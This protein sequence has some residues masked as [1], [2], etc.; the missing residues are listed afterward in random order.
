MA[1]IYI[2]VAEFKAHLSE[3]LRESTVNRKT[4]VVTRRNRPLVSIV[5]YVDE[6]QRGAGGLF[7]LAGTWTDFPEIASTIDRAYE[8]RQADGYRE[9]SL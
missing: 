6:G 3:I 2:S 7:S 5:P 9:V 4:I 8:S 1:D